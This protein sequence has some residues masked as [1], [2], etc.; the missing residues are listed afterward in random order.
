MYYEKRPNQILRSYCLLKKYSD[1][2]KYKK[3]IIVSRCEV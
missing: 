1:G 3:S 2:R